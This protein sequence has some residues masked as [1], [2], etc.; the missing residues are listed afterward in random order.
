MHVLA[1][2]SKSACAHA[3]GAVD[4]ASQSLVCVRPRAFEPGLG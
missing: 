2:A 1:R 3:R 4:D